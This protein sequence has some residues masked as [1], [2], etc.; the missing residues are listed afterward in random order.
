M[1]PAPSTPAEPTH[2]EPGYRGTIYATFGTTN[3]A[4][5]HETS[6]KLRRDLH[7]ITATPTTL[8]QL[9]SSLKSAHVGVRLVLAGPPADIKAAAAT[10]TE[11]GLVEEEITLLGEE[12]GPLVLF[13]A[14][15]RT[16]TMTTQAT[17]TE[18]DCP[19]CTT[20]LAI[21]NHFSRR[22]GAYLG[23]SAHAEEAA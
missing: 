5:H 11:C 21:S 15:C 1:H 4:T 9:A 6:A 22:M 18:L 10:A 13:C 17:G 3:T 19:G 2:C 23:F 20:T 8:T 14:H 12:T 7:F 16:T